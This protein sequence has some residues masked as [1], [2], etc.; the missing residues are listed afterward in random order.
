MVR[1]GGETGR[2][3]EIAIVGVSLT[4]AAAL[5][6]GAFGVGFDPDASGEAR[7][8]SL[9]GEV[10]DLLVAEWDR[11]RG[12]ERLPV[13]SVE[14]GGGEGLALVYEEPRPPEGGPGRE[15]S[16]FEERGD[17]A[18][19]ALLV[20]ASRAP[21]PGAALQFL[22]RA[23]EGE[24]PSVRRADAE[25]RAL[26]AAMDSGNHVAA[27]GHYGALEGEATREWTLAG[28]SLRLLALLAVVEAFGSE[29]DERVA[30]HREAARAWV[31]GE[32][33]LPPGGRWILEP[34][35]SSGIRFH[36]NPAREV[37]RER[38][39][40]I[41]GDGQAA[42]WLTGDLEIQRTRAL[43]A[44]LGFLP[45]PT[46]DRWELHGEGPICFG[47]RRDAAGRVEGYFVD[48]AAWLG[49]WAN[50]V[51]LPEGFSVKVPGEAS[52]AAERVGPETALGG[53]SLAFAL[54]HRD[55]EGA[56]RA[57]ADQARTLRIAFVFL[58]C[59]TLV[60]GFSGLRL[61]RRERELARLRTG[62]VSRVSHE[63]RTP[64]ASI[65]LLAEN[66]EADRHPDAASRRG[67][68]RTIHE[69]AERLRR[70]VANILD[71][72]RVDRGQGVSVEPEEL[73]LGP[74]LEDVG[75][76]ARE[77]ARR[78]EVELDVRIGSHGDE[79]VLDGDAVRRVVLNLVD[80][81]CRYGVEGPDNAVH[82]A[83]LL[84]F[85]DG[86]G[87]ELLLRVTDQGPGIPAASRERVFEAFR[88]LDERA[89]RPG[90]GL[91]LSIVR[92]IARAHGGE[93][94]VVD[95]PRGAGACIEVRFSTLE[96]DAKAGNVGGA[97]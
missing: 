95:A 49:E 36:P 25:W 10:G 48:R 17:S 94:R 79:A 85:E 88:R 19:E 4:S 62:F 51:S 30:L 84:E 8:Q 67:A 76:G 61:L 21:D 23:L 27:R 70:L 55:P 3:R 28:T 14:V 65:L 83:V 53:S 78:L 66:L 93:A 11:V 68:A 42:A 90:T 58:A 41:S 39:E 82:P 50:R 77:H 63:L 35:E 92:A 22:E 15:I 9:V 24:A 73:A 71:F 43:G 75:Q 1:V 33:V 69:E 6:Y 37:L 38:L 97:R 7:F 5:L 12:Q 20:E 80:N 13:P 54:H 64:L 45:E 40:G 52:P 74:F 16:D 81:A 32:W 86:G 29:S 87:R 47:T 44:W 96:E 59:L 2:W 57:G 56:I 60:A 34:G 18:F 26:R 91:G 46:S 72:G 89:G 31:A